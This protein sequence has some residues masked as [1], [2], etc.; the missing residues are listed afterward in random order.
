MQWVVFSADFSAVGGIQCRLQCS[1]WYSV[2][3]SVQWVVF[4]AHFSAVGGIQCRLQ[5]SGW[6]S[7]Q[8][9]SAVGGSY[10]VKT[11]VQW[12]VFS[13]HFS[14]VGGIQC[15]LQCSG[16]QTSVHCCAKMCFLSAIAPLQSQNLDYIQRTLSESMCK[17]CI[18]RSGGRNLTPTLLFAKGSQRQ[19]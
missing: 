4:S 14:A 19:G 18:R 7:V 16:V 3:T 6:Y 12:V 5:C 10:S 15:T 13:A 8:T 11:S 9:S 17:V 1:G 2:Q